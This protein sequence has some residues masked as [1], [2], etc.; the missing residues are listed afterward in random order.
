MS[1][2]DKIKELQKEIDDVD[3]AVLI[4]LISL[5]AFGLGIAFYAM[6]L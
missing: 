3:T 4:G 5:V 6:H 2:E 1:K